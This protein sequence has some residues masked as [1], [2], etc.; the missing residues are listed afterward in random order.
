MFLRHPFH[1]QKNTSLDG[2]NLVICIQKT[3]LHTEYDV[4]GK[5]HYNCRPLGSRIPLTEA[6]LRNPM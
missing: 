6:L 5:S 1:N 3:S 2:C 4:I